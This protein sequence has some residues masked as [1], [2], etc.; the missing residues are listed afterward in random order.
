MQTTSQKV[1]YHLIVK[2]HTPYETSSID[3]FKDVS[4]EILMRKIEKEI[5]DLSSAEP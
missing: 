3:D 4:G 5:V 2:L 1:V